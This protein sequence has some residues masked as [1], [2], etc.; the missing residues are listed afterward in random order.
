MKKILFACDGPHFAEGA[1]DFV[2][3]LNE[4]EPVLL[5]GVFLANAEFSSL[6]N[7]ADGM[8]GPL[9]V[10]VVEQKDT[11]GVKHAVAR[12]EELCRKNNMTYRV[13]EDFYDFALAELRLE[14]RFADLLVI[15]SEHFYENLDG[16][17]N[18]YLLDTLHEAE[19]PVLILPD[20]AQYPEKLVLAYDGS[21]SSVFAIK[22]LNYIFPEWSSIRSQLVFIQEDEDIPE[23]PDQVP[24]EELAAR[25]YSDLTIIRMGGT[26]RKQFNQWISNQGNTLL[27]AGAYGR[28]GFSRLMK[29]SFVSE[30]I[31]NR[32]VP[33]FIAHR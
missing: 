29:K 20:E 11:V 27:V 13:H 23:V 15:G 14:T 1:F 6:W 17:P 12:F 9:F 25:H 22:Q 8:N 3:K 26:T 32:K 19:C 24:M 31:R 18:Q 16:I 28:S 7:F 33:V 2:R 21:P 5:T 30:V 4:Q 10:P